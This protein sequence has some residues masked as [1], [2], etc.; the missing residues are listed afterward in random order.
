MNILSLFVTIFLI[1]CSQPPAP[2]PVPP[3]PVPPVPTPPK[4]TFM[5]Q[6]KKIVVKGELK[7][8]TKVSLGAA[9]ATVKTAVS[10]LEAKSGF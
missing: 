2:V 8:G 7:D 4:Y 3:V 1:S 5:V 10:L 6:G 9:E